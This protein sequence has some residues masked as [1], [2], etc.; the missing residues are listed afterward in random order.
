MDKIFEF[1]TKYKSE[2]ANLGIGTYIAY[3]VAAITSIFSDTWELPITLGLLVA[4]TLGVLKEDSD[5]V[6]SNPMDFVRTVIG[7]ILGVVMW[8]L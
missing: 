4:G 6:N 3:F 7:A 2:V 8:L 5:G 1:L